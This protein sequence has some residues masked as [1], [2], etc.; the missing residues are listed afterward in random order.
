MEGRTVWKSKIPAR[1]ARA[2]D[3]PEKL[4]ERTVDIQPQIHREGGGVAA[5]FGLGSG[6]ADSGAGMHGDLV[7]M[8]IDEVEL[9]SDV[10]MPKVDVGDTGT[11]STPHV[12]RAAESQAAA[13]GRTADDGLLRVDTRRGNPQWDVECVLGSV[14]PWR[15]NA[16]PVQ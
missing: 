5:G 15:V 8:R 16:P 14:K 11:E 6:S 2:G 3:E 10:V 4:A 7:C 9:G 12:R 1:E 13:S